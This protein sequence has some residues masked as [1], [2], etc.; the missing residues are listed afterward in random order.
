MTSPREESIPSPLAVRRA[1][2]PDAGAVAALYAQLVANPA[3]DVLPARLDELRGSPDAAL[4]VATAGDA[5]VGTI[6]VA[7]CPDAMFGRRPFAVVENIV[8]AGASRGQG[9]G[10]AL[11]AEVERLCRVRDCSKVMLLSASE[12]VEAHRFFERNGYAGDRKR[13]FVKCRA[14]IAAG[15]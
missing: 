13:G 12:R 4:L 11:L 1:A 7:W 15:G 8:V 9:V 14:A 3:L 2:G 6:F 10:A 5:I